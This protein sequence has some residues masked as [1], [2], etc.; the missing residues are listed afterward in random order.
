MAAAIPVGMPKPLK[1]GSND[2][3]IVLAKLKANSSTAFVSGQF[4]ETTGSAPN[5]KL[6]SC[7]ASESS[8]RVTGWAQEDAAAST[9]IPPTA[10][11]GDY[12]SVLS[13]K[14]TLF[15]VNVTDASG[16]V[17]STSTTQADVTIGTSYE[18]VY[19]ETGYTSIPMVN[20][21]ATTDAFFKVVG[22]W[23]EDATTDFNGR[24]ICSIVA[25]R[26]MD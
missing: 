15:V 9:T 12:S 2:M 10:L 7:T 25:T 26:E 13:V 23:P 24:V 5:Q 6:T 1:Y 20:K 8:P 22:Y 14:D 11:Y 17:G 4:V 16:H 19:G 21:A 18:L 3:P